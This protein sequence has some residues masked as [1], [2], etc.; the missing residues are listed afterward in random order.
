MNGGDLLLL[1][2]FLVAILGPD[3]YGSIVVEAGGGDLV[4]GRV[5]GDGDHRV[6]V[7]LQLLDQILPLQVPQVDAVILRSADDIFPIC[8]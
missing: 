6:L 2:S 5:A 3:A 8:H 4:L 1:G 7:A